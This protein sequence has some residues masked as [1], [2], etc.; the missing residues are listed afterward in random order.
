MTLQTA[1]CN[2]KQYV[3][4][5]GSKKLVPKAMV[6]SWKWQ[7]QPPGVRESGYLSLDCALK[8]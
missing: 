8:S 6:L 4:I 7:K 1:D 5:Q 3:G 2:L